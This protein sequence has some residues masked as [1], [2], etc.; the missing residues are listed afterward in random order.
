[1][2]IDGLP[3]RKRVDIAIAGP[4]SRRR[5]SLAVVRSYFDVLHARYTEVGAKAAVPLPDHL[6]LD[7]EYDYLRKHEDSEGSDYQVPI[8]G[9]DRKYRVG[10]L[11]DRVSD[12]RVRLP[13][14][15]GPGGD[16]F[17]INS[18]G[19]VVA[20]GSNTEVETA[21]RPADESG[22][23]PDRL[24]EWAGA[25][26][27]IGGVLGAV[28]GLGRHWARSGGLDER[29]RLIWARTPSPVTNIAPRSH[30]R[31]PEPT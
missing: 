20:G 7:A 21:A 6:D 11:L 14:A 12:E 28:F 24:Q 4:A 29:W 31:E 16:T 3:D 5:E 18:P 2:L 25:G 30:D 9:A 22:G 26:A 13:A 8:P 1:M 10:D 17:V 27:M 19:A 23:L 15:R